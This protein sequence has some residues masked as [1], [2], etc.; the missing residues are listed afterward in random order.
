M[1]I[2]Q[3]LAMIV[4]HLNYAAKYD[5]TYEEHAA[6]RPRRRQSPAWKAPK[7]ESQSA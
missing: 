1:L 2:F 6:T 4:N 3:I 5:G 7:A